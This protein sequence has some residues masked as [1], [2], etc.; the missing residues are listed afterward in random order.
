MEAR[1]PRQPTVT[2]TAAPVAG[3]GGLAVSASKLLLSGIGGEGQDLSETVLA[4]LM[5]LEA[6]LREA[7]RVSAREVCSEVQRSS[8]VQVESR[9]EAFS[10]ALDELRCDFQK[11][12]D[13][14][15]AELRILVR[16]VKSTSPN[17]GA[18]GISKEL[19]DKLIGAGLPAVTAALATGASHIDGNSDVVQGARHEASSLNLVQ[20]RNGIEAGERGEPRCSTTDSC[21]TSNSTAASTRQV[22]SSLLENSAEEHLAR[23]DEALEREALERQEGERRLQRQIDGLQRRLRGESAAG[24]EVPKA[25]FIDGV[26]AEVPTAAAAT[27]TGLGP[28]SGT[29]TGAAAAAA[30]EWRHD[31][32]VHF[33]SAAKELLEQYDDEL[34]KAR[35]AYECRLAA[36]EQ[37][38]HQQA[39]AVGSALR[40]AAERCGQ[41]VPA[42]ASAPVL[43][44]VPSGAGF[45]AAAL[46]ATRAV[47]GQ[48]S[49][50]GSASL[51]VGGQARHGA[52]GS[53]SGGGGGG[54]S[55]SAPPAT[56][57]TPAARAMPAAAEP[58]GQL[59][60]G[61][62]PGQARWQSEDSAATASLVHRNS[63]RILPAQAQNNR[64]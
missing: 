33:E 7:S 60:G 48:E 51:P 50:P 3:S 56:P 20:L 37:A 11:L 17:E 23:L 8:E 49:C 10:G 6:R 30:E 54:G 62:G 42:T 5:E 44:P 38:M 9:L 35:Q 55:G 4:N 32:R 52:C 21:S 24:H 18:A 36:F 34:R 29:G 53:G 26:R 19:K 22:M 64:V 45:G 40:R 61:S 2:T 58:L 47:W 1:T 25:A 28:Q 16:E 63:W 57:L 43:T 41:E 31:L 15:F 46:A 27:G 39:S 13:L 14:V 59:G 12:M